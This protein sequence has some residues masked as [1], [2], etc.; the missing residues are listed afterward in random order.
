MESPHLAST[1]TREQNS[2]QSHPIKQYLFHWHNFDVSLQENRLPPHL[3]ANGTEKHLVFLSRIHLSFL[4]YT[5]THTYTTHK[6]QSTNYFYLKRKPAD[7]SCFL[8]CYACGQGYSTQSPSLLF[9]VYLYCCDSDDSADLLVQGVEMKDGH[10]CVTSASPMTLLE[11]PHVNHEDGAAK[12]QKS[13]FLIS[14]L[15]RCSELP[16]SRLLVTWGKKGRLEKIF[17]DFYSTPVLIHM[18]EWTNFSLNS[19]N[20]YFPVR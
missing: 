8:L 18:S 7:Y 20:P 9:V 3:D 10:C 4:S 16:N 12:R 6:I 19:F 14:P 2:I 13:D 5:H 15:H 17:L 11:K 1:I